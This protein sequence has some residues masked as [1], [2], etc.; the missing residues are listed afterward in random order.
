MINFDQNQDQQFNELLSKA[1]EN[2]QTFNQHKNQ[3]KI[4][5]LKLIR[6][7]LNEGSE[8]IM[9]VTNNNSEIANDILQKMS[10]AFN[11]TFKDSENEN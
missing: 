7:A 5:N 11:E 3:N 1:F 8:Y 10:S 2:A 4:M 9:E 6:E